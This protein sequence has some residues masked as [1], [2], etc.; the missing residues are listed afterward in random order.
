M[1][2]STSRWCALLPISG[3]ENWAIPQ[4]CLA[5]IVTVASTLDRPPESLHWRSMDIPVLD[6]TSDESVPWLQSGGDSGLIGVIQG[7]EGYDCGYWGIA[8]RG[9]SLSMKDLATIDLLDRP[10][11][12]VEHSNAAFELQGTL[13]QV[14]DLPKLQQQVSISGDAT[15]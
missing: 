5:E 11:S 12:R 13:Y 14:P 15:T 10:E 9:S 3:L 6:L 1:N 8:L 2:G 7:L 4:I